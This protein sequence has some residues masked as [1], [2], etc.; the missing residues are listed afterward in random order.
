MEKNLKKILECRKF[1]R[2]NSPLSCSFCGESWRRGKFKQFVN[3]YK[4]ADNDSITYLVIKS[5][6][7]NTLGQGIQDVYAL[8]EELKELKKRGKISDFYS[9]F[10]VSFSKNTLGFNPHLN[11]LFFGDIGGI[12]AMAKEHN[13]SVWS[14]KKKNDE[15]TVKSIIWYMLKYNKIGQEEGEAVKKALDRRRTILHTKRFN[16]KNIN[17]LDDFLDLD[18]SFLGVYPIRSKAELKLREEIKNEKKKLNLKLKNFKL[19]HSHD[20]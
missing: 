13:L 12:K 3:T 11:I 17:Y 8:I 1:K 20:F 15:N 14:C 19:S 6:S 2:C 18:F 7:L 5:N 4:V 9:R 16:H 10:E